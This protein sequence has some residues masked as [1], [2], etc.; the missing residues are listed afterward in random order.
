MKIITK[1]ILTIPF[2]YW[3]IL[4]VAGNFPSIPMAYYTYAT[5]WILGMIILFMTVLYLIYRINKKQIEREKRNDIILYMFIFIP[6]MIYYI[7]YIDDKLQ[8]K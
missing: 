3:I 2:I 4:L 8:D 6:Y 5:L 1:I 7:W